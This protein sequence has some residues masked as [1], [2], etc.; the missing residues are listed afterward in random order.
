MAI[1]FMLINVQFIR[2]FPQFSFCIRKAICAG[3][4]YIVRL[5]DDQKIIRGFQYINI[6]PSLPQLTGKVLSHCA[7]EALS[8]SAI[9]CFLFV[10]CFNTCRCI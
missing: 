7:I 3:G 10:K 1:P 6:L 2:G 5:M 9:W 8:H 4:T